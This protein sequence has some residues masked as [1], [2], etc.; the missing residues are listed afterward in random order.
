MLAFAS[1]C[2]RLSSLLLLACSLLT[3]SEDLFDNTIHCNLDVGSIE[4]DLFESYCFMAN[5]F[6]FEPSKEDGGSLRLRHQS[7]GDWEEGLGKEDK[8][9]TSQVTCLSITIICHGL[10]FTQ[11]CDLIP[12]TTGIL[13]V[14]G[15]GAGLPSW[16]LLST[17]AGL[18][19]D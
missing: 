13:P 1:C 6:T 11:K 19:T 4:L 2:K 17:L 9:N 14:G 3:T 10:L 16:S 5:T 8:K 15:L 12:H 7:V 18:E